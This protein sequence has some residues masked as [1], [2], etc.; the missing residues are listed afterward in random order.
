MKN[1]NKLNNIIRYTI[2]LVLASYILQR[3]E[4]QKFKLHVM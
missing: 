3:F 1:K 2:L 4:L